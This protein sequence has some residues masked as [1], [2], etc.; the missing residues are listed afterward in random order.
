MDAGEQKTLADV[1]QYGCH[2]LHIL[3]EGDLPP[4]SYSVGIEKTS[5]APELVVIGLKRAVAHFIINEYNRRIRQGECFEADQMVSGFLKGFECQLRSV[6]FSHYREYF[7][8]ALAFYKGSGF[9]VLQLVYPT[10]E[11]V[12]PWE[13]SANEWF[14]SWQPLLEVPAPEHEGTD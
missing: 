10:V 7:G 13:A 3:E 11:G 12:W 5:Q 1:Q 8:A 14:R 2:V 6:H 4:F 9:R